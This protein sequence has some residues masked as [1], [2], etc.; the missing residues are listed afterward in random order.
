MLKRM[1]LVVLK[2]IGFMLYSPIWLIKEPSGRGRW[3]R[4]QSR[5]MVEERPPL[6]DADFLRVQQASAADAPVWLAARRCLA[7]G[8]GVPREAIRPEDRM[9]DLWRMQRPGPDLLDLILR[10]E[11]LLG[12]KI[13]RGTITEEFRGSW[14]EEFSPFAAG[15]V[16]A[17]REPPRP[18][19]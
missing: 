18:D 14:P 6:A 3:C 15:I 7:G 5:R 4:R 13:P 1:L 16:R 19:G 11:I 17:L 10:L 12:R 2:A 8:I 9:A